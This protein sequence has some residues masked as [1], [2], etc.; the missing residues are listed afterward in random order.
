MLLSYPVN[1][2]DYLRV[3]AVNSSQ[4][5]AGYRTSIIF[6]SEFWT[7]SICLQAFV[8]V[9]PLFQKVLSPPYFFA[10]QGMTTHPSSPDSQFIPEEP[11]LLLWTLSSCLCF[12]WFEFDVYQSNFGFH[13]DLIKKGKHKNVLSSKKRK[14]NFRFCA[15]NMLHLC[16]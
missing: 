10:S 16:Q 12:H 15:G 9:D 6:T 13:S 4:N 11:S 7:T 8:P 5:N 2:N 14:I 3:N 1:V